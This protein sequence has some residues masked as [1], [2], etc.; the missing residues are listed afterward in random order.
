[1][2]RVDTRG[3]SCPMPVIRLK[4][5]IAQD[6]KEDILVMVDNPSSKENVI[7]LALSAGF[8]LVNIKEDGK[9]CYISIR[10][11]EETADVQV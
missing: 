9:D 4:K 2:I 3:M 7:R 1:M 6:P 5:V 11:K 10:P 8:I